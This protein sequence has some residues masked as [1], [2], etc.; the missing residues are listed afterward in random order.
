MKLRPL[1]MQSKQRLK[2]PWDFFCTHYCSEGT[3]KDELIKRYKNGNFL[4]PASFAKKKTNLGISYQDSVL[5]STNP[6]R[7][8]SSTENHLTCFCKVKQILF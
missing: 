8:Q 4:I 2:A 3:S 7:I 6:Q 5:S 1:G